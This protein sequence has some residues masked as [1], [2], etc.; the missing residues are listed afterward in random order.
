VK[1]KVVSIN[2]LMTSLDVSGESSDG[3]ADNI[4]RVPNNSFFQKYVRCIPGKGTQ[5]LKRYMAEHRE[6]K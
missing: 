6:V 4:M 2:M 5:S 3:S 1:G